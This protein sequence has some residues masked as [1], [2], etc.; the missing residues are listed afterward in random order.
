MALVLGVLGDSE[1]VV[2]L[3]AHLAGS[4]QDVVIEVV[5]LSVCVDNVVNT[6]EVEGVQERLIEGD[7]DGHTV[8]KVGQKNLSIVD[9]GIDKSFVLIT[10]IV[11]S[12]VRVSR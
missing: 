4:L 1:V 3:D 11:V 6:L 8:G 5:D 10:G 12:D 2:E 9:K 7:P